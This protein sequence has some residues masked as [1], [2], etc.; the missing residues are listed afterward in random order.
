MS[1]RH[2]TKPQDLG[3]DGLKPGQGTRTLRASVEATGWATDLCTDRA[4]RDVARGRILA[5]LA[6]GVREVSW[7][8]C[9]LPRER[10]AVSPRPGSGEWSALRHVHHLTLR[11]THLTL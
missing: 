6:E 11:E 5:W 9:S 7:A 10:W 8:L 4:T 3:P 2:A 1:F